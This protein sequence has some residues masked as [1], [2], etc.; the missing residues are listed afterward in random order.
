MALFSV[1][2]NLTIDTSGDTSLSCQFAMDSV[3]RYAYLPGENRVWR[4]S[5]TGAVE[6][7][8]LQGAGYQFVSLAYQ[9]GSLQGACLCSG[10]PCGKGPGV[11]WCTV[12]V[13]AGFASSGAVTMHGWFDGLPRATDWGL[14]SCLSA[15]DPARGL[16][17]YS[18][19]VA[20][21]VA[22]VDVRSSTSLPKLV[23]ST[24]VSDL[25]YL[26]AASDRAYGV[27]EAASSLRVMSFNNSDR[28]VIASLP[29][30]LQ[31][32]SSGSAV[33]EASAGLMHIML[34]R[35]NIQFPLLSDCTLASVALDGSSTT[36]AEANI[37][38]V[39]QK[40]FANYFITALSP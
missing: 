5:A 30:D 7:R 20:P 38:A 23:I 28:R 34:R 13:D 18:P 40:V 8:Q 3:G 4:I 15:L 25:V 10:P 29:P 2:A 39:D 9:N 35:R 11:R 33:L 12:D 16:F 14:S 31:M 36:F 22:V 21:N 27:V 37:S 24:S 19:N 6:S 17:A 32:A 26:A 1:R